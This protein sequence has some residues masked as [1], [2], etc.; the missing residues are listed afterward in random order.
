M[1]SLAQISAGRAARRRAGSQTSGDIG[2]RG[3]GER[4]QAGID[5]A[6]RFETAEQAASLVLGEN[7][8]DAEL[9]GEFAKI[10]ERRRRIG[11]RQRQQFAR[12]FFRGLTGEES[13]CSYRHSDLR[14]MTFDAENVL[15]F[16]CYSSLWA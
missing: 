14:R 15:G 9:G 4:A 6:E 12:Y 13:D 16:A 5:A 1:P 11:R 10:E 2:S 8:R 7:L 3:A